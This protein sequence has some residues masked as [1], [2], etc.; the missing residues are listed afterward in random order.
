[1]LLT[2]PNNVDS[3][4]QFMTVLIIFVFVL[5]VTYWTTKWI[6]GYQK[7]KLHNTNME[8]IEAIRLTNNKYIQIIRVGQ[9]YLAVAICKDSV[10]MLT[11]ISEDQLILSDDGEGME[12]FNFKELLEKV[13]KKNF[14]GKEDDRNENE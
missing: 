10:T 6:A 12:R 1:M 9:K 2:A 4:L 5:V 8:L 7:G 3:Y 14:S 13:Q 11:E